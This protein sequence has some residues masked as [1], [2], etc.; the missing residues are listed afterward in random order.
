M[1]KTCYKITNQAKFNSEQGHA[2][3]NSPIMKQELKQ[4]HKPNQERM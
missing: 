3:E 1:K 2:L 4:N